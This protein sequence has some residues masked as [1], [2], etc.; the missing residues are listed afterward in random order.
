MSAK[1]KVI[2]MV[3]AAAVALT[4]AAVVG[5]GRA[6]ASAAPPRPSQPRSVA[7]VP[8]EHKPVKNLITLSGAFRPFQEVDLH[9]KV[10]GYIRN[11]NV[12][13]GDRVSTGQVLA[14]L[15]VPELAAQ[16][17][18]SEADIHRRE[19]DIRRAQSEI[20]R[21]ESVHSAAHFGYTRLKQA[22]QA[23]PGLIAEQE[24]DDAM[25][26]DKASEAQVA[27][28]EAALS[29]AKQELAVAQAN[30]A[31]MSAMAGYTRLT[32]PF[33][34]VVTKR[35]ADTGALIPA[36]TST[37]T[38]ALPVVRLAETSILRLIF[39]VPES[40]VPLIHVGMPVDVKVPALNRTFAGHVT[41]YDDSLD[42]Q[43]RTMN[44]EIDVENKDGSLVPGMYAE[45]NFALVNKENA[46]TVPVQAVSRSGS[47]ASVLVVD[48]HNRIEE[49]Q[50]QLGTEGTD[51]VEITSGLA[52]GER[53]VIGSRS[54]FRPGEEVT[55]K[56]VSSSDTKL[57]AEL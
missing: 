36:G 24:L 15:E 4:L 30:H 31:Q 25:A 40:A 10:A 47:Q 14:V 52:E 13:I 57:E 23:R 2:V 41:R 11:I 37:T 8:V 49:R 27:M 5:I 26:K 34:G 35:Y 1:G 56:T 28:A 9:A 42:Q 45:S 33:P 54:Q 46:L 21:S 43:T 18:G 51:R 53:V 12:D 22:A 6:R 3:A 7:V 39:P 20:A 16:L 32:A 44:T 50:V 55:P 29:E 38:P 48:A 19:E 17:Q